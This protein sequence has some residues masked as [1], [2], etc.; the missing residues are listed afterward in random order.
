MR[1][2]DHLN[3]HKWKPGQSGNPGGRPKKQSMQSALEKVLDASPEL[4]AELIQTGLEQAKKG[5][6]RYWQ[7]IFN[8]LDGKVINKV[9]LTDKQVD[10]SALDNEGDTQRPAVNPA[11][12][13]SISND[14][15]A[16]V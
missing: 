16:D 7:E 11:R 6:F 12:V 10:W 14:S 13:K 5:D 3:P 15:Q 9:E 4:L 1:S 8:R 2:Y